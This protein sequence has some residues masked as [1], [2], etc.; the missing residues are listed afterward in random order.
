MQQI[1][2]EYLRETLVYAFLWSI[3]VFIITIM[4]K[5]LTSAITAMIVGGASK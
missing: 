2:K 4:T 5:E 3:A 1:P